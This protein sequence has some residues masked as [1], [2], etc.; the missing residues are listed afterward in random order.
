MAITGVQSPM[1]RWSPQTWFVA[2]LLVWTTAGRLEAQTG[3]AHRP[4]PRA[5]ASIPAEQAMELTNGWARLAEGRPAEAMINAQRVLAREPRSIEGLTLAV[6]ADISGHGALAGLL[7]YEHWLAGRTLE[8]PGILRRVARAVLVEAGAQRA[9]DQARVEALRSLAGDRDPQAAHDVQVGINGAAV[10]PRSRAALGDTRATAA[11]IAELNR[12]GPGQVKTIEALAAAGSEQAIPALVARLK[13]PRQ[14]IR[15][16]AVAALGAL[17]N[18]QV[19]PQLSGLLSDQDLAV[20]TAA[21]GAL[22][23]LGD[24]SGIQTLQTGLTDPSPSVRLLAAEAMASQ[25][26]G[27]WMS[28]VRDLAMS[29]DPEVRAAAARLLGPHDPEF[30]RSVLNALAADE[31]PAIRE[32][33]AVDMGEVVTTDLT[34]LRA[35]LKSEAT[36]T[37]VR[38]A[39]QVLSL[40]R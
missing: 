2:L 37:R 16:A 9:D 24:S 38:A 12:G 34:A 25:P 40:T 23:R 11:L 17:G 5:A 4:S 1:S 15:T 20:R 22:L 19:V 21:A 31:N 7:Q 39:G 35:L 36:L 13:D 3:P 18:T 6:E 10:P 26:D 8:E 30:A 32:L 14:E 28:V 27:S 29:E 33:A